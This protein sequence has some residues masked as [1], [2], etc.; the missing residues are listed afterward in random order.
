MAE[1]DN[2]D[3][4]LLQDVKHDVDINLGDVYDFLYLWVAY[5]FK[6]MNLRGKLEIV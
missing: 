3:V 5:K 6:L 4:L 2:A 1:F